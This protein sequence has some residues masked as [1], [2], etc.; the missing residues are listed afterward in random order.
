MTMSYPKKEVGDVEVFYREAG[1]AGAPVI[2]LL[3][4]F[5][6][7]SHMF[8]NLIPAL[9]RATLIAF[10]GAGGPLKAPLSVPPAGAAKREGQPSLRRH[11]KT[12]LGWQ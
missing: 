3:H 8:R 7:S 4:G 2:L 1:P 9:A 12:A 6:T 10:Y 5:P 11:R